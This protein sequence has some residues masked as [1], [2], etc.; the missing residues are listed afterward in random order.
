ML[1]L[2]L[3]CRVISSIYT[4]II[5]ECR[6]VHAHRWPIETMRYT[7]YI[8]NPNL[9]IDIIYAERAQFEER[10]RDIHLDEGPRLLSMISIDEALL[11]F[12]E[13]SI[14]FFFLCVYVCVCVRCQHHIRWIDCGDEVINDQE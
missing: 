3:S 10:K 13:V 9:H 6:V 4:P 5:Y 11:R 8:K 1:A 12:G 7:R 2:F 14:P